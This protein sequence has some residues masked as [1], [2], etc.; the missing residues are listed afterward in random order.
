MYVYRKYRNIMQQQNITQNSIRQTMVSS[1]SRGRNINLHIY[2]QISFA[3]LISSRANIHTM[4]V[5]LFLDLFLSFAH[6]KILLSCYLKPS[7]VIEYICVNMSR[8]FK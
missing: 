5:N 3:F 7:S 6:S 8:S 1:D 2:H 4:L